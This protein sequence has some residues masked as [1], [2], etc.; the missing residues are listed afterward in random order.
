MFFK[1]AAVLKRSDTSERRRI[2]LCS[3]GETCTSP[4]PFGFNG[5]EKEDEVYGE[6]NAYSFEYR[7]HDPRV[8]RF[9]RLDPI[10]RDYPWNSP[11]VFAENRVIQGV[12]FEG[13]EFKDANGNNTANVANTQLGTNNFG[14]TAREIQYVQYLANN[15]F[16]P[17]NGVAG[18]GNV[19][20]YNPAGIAQNPNAQ[21]L[22]NQ[23]FNITSGSN[24]NLEA[25]KAGSFGTSPLIKEIGGGFED[26]LTPDGGVSNN[27][28][29][30]IVQQ[31]ITYGSD[32]QQTPLNFV[33]AP[34]I[35]IAPAPG[36]PGGA[37]VVGA[38]LANMDWQVFSDMTGRGVPG[39]WQN[40]LDFRVQQ[41][42]Q[43]IQSTDGST[44]NAP[45]NYGIR[46]SDNATGPINDPR[47]PSG[48]TRIPYK[49]NPR[50]A[51]AAEAPT[52]YAD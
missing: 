32:Q 46:P 40:I 49:D 22:Y 35:N 16:I 20:V 36:V 24:D 28:H 33:P 7:I 12:D 2:P 6:G 38:P 17:S 19:P 21:V 11:Y 9:L 50:G 39:N 14:L 29:N 30:Y 37:V 15:G 10:F 18:T 23:M 25:W 45:N 3:G 51:R 41:G 26:I 13:L 48:F 44:S 27:F 52:N 42:R 1:A 34:G 31:M 8:G 47:R 5:Q 4:Y 43:Y